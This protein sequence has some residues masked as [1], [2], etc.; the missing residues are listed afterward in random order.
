MPGVGGVAG[1]ERK[2]A[3]WLSEEVLGV[4]PRLP[5]LPGMLTGVKAGDQPRLL[6]GLSFSGVMLSRVQGE[7]GRE[8]L[9]G[10]KRKLCLLEM[11]EA[12]ELEEEVRS[13][14]LSGRA[15]TLSSVRG[16]DRK[17][18]WLLS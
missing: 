14:V 16:Q 7:K 15:D 6:T 18:T 4:R 3:A 12:A 8:N 10:E 2:L 17:G 11:G 1:A 9:S 13:V 5:R